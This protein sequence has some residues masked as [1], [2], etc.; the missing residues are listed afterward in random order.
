MS[1]RFNRSIVFFDLPTIT[2]AD[3]RNYNRFR[4]MLIKNGYIMLQESV[5]CRMITTENMGKTLENL[6]IQNKPPEGMTM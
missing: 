1:D 3:R 4:K 2:A 5:Y 6:I